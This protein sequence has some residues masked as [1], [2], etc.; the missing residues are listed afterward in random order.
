MYSVKSIARRYSPRPVECQTALRYAESMKRGLCIALWALGTY[1]M[2][3][4]GVWCAAEVLHKALANVR[5]SAD[6]AQHLGMMEVFARGLLPYV[7]GSIVFC[8]GLGA[9]LPG[10]RK[11]G[12]LSAE[13]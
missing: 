6:V 13:N 3:I 7:A 2:S 11:T 12:R 4:I 5:M 8:A 1:V 9:H 10:T